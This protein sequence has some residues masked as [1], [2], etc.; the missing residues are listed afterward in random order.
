MSKLWVKFRSNN[1]TRVSTE[2]CEIVDDFLEACKKKLSP[3]LDSIPASRLSLS[4]T[5]GGTALR[6]GL[7]LTAIPS[8]PGYVENDDEHPLFIS[9][10]EQVQQSNV[11][12][13]LRSLGVEFNIRDVNHLLINYTEKYSLLK[14]P[15]LTKK[16]A[17]AILTFAAS[18]IKSATQKAIGQQH[19]F[20]LDGSLNASQGQGKSSMYYAFSQTGVVL[21]A[22]VYN[23]EYKESFSREVEA[24]NKL[25]HKN[26]VKFIKTFSIQNE[27]RHIIIMPFFPRSV[28]DMLDQDY[29]IPLATVRV[30]A[31]DCFDALSYMHSK[32]LCFADLKPAN[33]MLQNAE[34]GHATLVDYGAIVQIDTGI[35]EYTS[36]F[37]LDADAFVGTEHL[38]WICLGTTLA[39]IAGFDISN[40]QY[41]ADLVNEV[42]RSAI[43]V[44]LKQ[45]IVACLQKPTLVGIA[46]AINRFSI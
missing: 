13:K 19:S 37:C 8:Q 22:K 21:V 7:L 4:T 6:P 26:L 20:F 2:G 23:S 15:Q 43:N 34:H 40:F 10:A 39:Q 32:R 42:N 41:A 12:D 16:E 17:Q 3:D 11:A 5:D 38:D 24:N 45:L 9:V 1:P 27:A 14:S 33:I 29:Q 31:R 25:D 36:V 30:I 18:K 35:I 28:A 44:H 46:E